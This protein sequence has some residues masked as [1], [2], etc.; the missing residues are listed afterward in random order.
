MSHLFRFAILAVSASLLLLGAADAQQRGARQRPARPAGPPPQGRAVPRHPVHPPPATV[1]RGSVFI[2]GYFYDPFYGPYPWWY[3][4]AYPYWYHPVYD[5]RADLRI[6]VTPDDA[7]EAGVYVDGFYAGQVDDFDGAF[8]SLP[9]TPGG[10]TIVLYLEGYRTIR[11]NLYLQRGSTF[12]LRETLVRLPAGERSDPP[13]L[14]PA[15][16]APPEGTYKLPVTPPTAAPPARA[17]A[18]AAPAVGFGTVDLFVQPAD[19]D[20]TIDGEKWVSS[21]SGHFMVQV[22]PGTHRV[23]IS[24]PGFP[25]FAADIVVREGESTPLNVSLTP[26]SSDQ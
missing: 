6:Q 14:A 9:L 8:Q 16:P 4:T 22:R 13:V 17:D 1:V 24:K 18:A 19:A 7:D 15:V 5:E 20:V 11:H 25:R 3:R 12:R 10:H 21:D 23:E 2:G 26:T